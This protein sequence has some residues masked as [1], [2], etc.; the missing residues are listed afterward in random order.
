MATDRRYNVLMKFTKTG[1]R[2]IWSKCQHREHAFGANVC[3]G[4]MPLEQMSV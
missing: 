1:V 2:S 3:I 4:N